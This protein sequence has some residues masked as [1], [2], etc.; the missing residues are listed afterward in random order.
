MTNKLSMKHFA[1][2]LILLISTAFFAQKN[3]YNTDNGYF[4]EGFDVVSYFTEKAPKTGNKKHQ[5]TYDGV[6]FLFLSK[7]NLELFKANPKKYIPQYGGYCAYAVGAKNIKKATDPESFEI[8]EGKLYVFYNNFFGNKLDDW[9]EGDTKKLKKQA[10]INW[11]KLK[12][13][14]K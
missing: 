8:R 6:K 9:K 3:D 1:T 4:L 14:N 7:E 11:E 12:N 2:I 5:T 13:K 10:D